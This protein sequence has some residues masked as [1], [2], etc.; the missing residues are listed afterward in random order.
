MNAGPQLVSRVRADGHERAAAERDLAAIADENVY[1]DSGECEDQE[2]QQNGAQQIVA[3]ERPNVESCQQRHPDEGDTEQDGERYTV[4][5]DREDRHILRVSSLEL[6]SLAIKHS[7]LLVSDTFDDPLAEQPLRPHEQHR[8]RQHICEPIF[9]TATHMRPQEHLGDLLARTHNEPADDGSWNGG[10]APDDE[11]RQGLQR[12]KRDGEL[13]AQLGTPHGRRNQRNETGSKPDYEP[14]PADWNPDR[15]RGQVV[16]GNRPECATGLSTLEEDREARDQ[17]AGDKAA[18]D[19][20]LVDQNSARKAT[21]EQEPGVRREQPQ[22]V[23]IG[24][25][26]HLRRTLE[27]ECHANRGHEQR[28]AVLVDK[29][30]DHEPLDQPGRYRHDHDGEAD[31]EDD[32]SPK[33]EAV[34]YQEVERANQRK[35]CEQYHCTLG[36]IED[37]G[38]F[39][40]QHEAKRD[41]RIQHAGHQSADQ[42]FEKLTERDHAMLLNARRRDRRR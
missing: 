7:S 22:R 18:P 38:C 8:Q 12:K 39:E 13:Y 32:R 31:A 2:G 4:L 6:A 42:H 5:T 1:A 27:D 33:R 15:L 24:T 19:I 35:P 23:S 40:D 9:D 28:E 14:D 34:G 36:K 17:N 20:Q 30:S 29:R 3:A 25:E 10:Q 11:N 41:Q 26:D 16:V 37:T 21:F